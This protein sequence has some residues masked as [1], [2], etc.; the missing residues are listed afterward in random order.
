MADP[1]SEEPRT[2]RN[3]QDGPVVF[4]YGS[5]QRDYILWEAAG[6]PNGEDIVEVPADVC[7]IPQ[8]RKNMKNGIFAEVTDR[9]EIEGAEALQKEHWEKVR[10]GVGMEAEP[11]ERPEDNSYEALKCI[12]PADNGNS[13]HT[14]GAVL[15]MKLADLKEK[16]P[17]CSRHKKLAASFVPFESQDE[18]GNSS[19]Q[20]SQVSLSK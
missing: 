13:K 2:I 10:D 11:L 20:W 15:T 4:S 5:G 8:F 16:P 1:T 6:D 19:T 18:Q 3:T 7:R 12:G 17:L 14:C 9:D